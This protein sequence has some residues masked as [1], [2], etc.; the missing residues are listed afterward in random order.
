MPEVWPVLSAA[1]T[2]CSSVLR[3][4]AHILP[5]AST[6]SLQPSPCCVKA[7]LP[8]ALTLRVSEA[9]A[10]L[11]QT[12]WHSS[13]HVLGE[14]LESCFGA[15]LTIGPALEEGFY[16]DCY[17]GERTLTEADKAALEKQIQQVRSAALPAMC[18]ACTTVRGVE[19]SLGRLSARLHPCY[20]PSAA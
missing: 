3:W 15:K 7:M 10:G 12:F 2:D 1:D 20:F 16:Y 6:G 9:A 18:N 8:P 17:L 14:A 19:A 11:A 4:A 5:Q 13:A